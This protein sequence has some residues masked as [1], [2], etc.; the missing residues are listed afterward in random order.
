MITKTMGRFSVL[1]RMAAVLAG[2]MILT[3]GGPRA[4]ASVTYV[5]ESGDIHVYNSHL[6]FYVSTTGSNMGNLSTILLD[7]QELAGPTSNT[8]GGYFD[9]NDDSSV[10]AS[11]YLRLGHHDAANTTITP[12]KGVASTG[13]GF[14]DITIHHSSSSV[15]A[16][17]VTQH[18]VLSD[19]ENGIHM[20]TTVTNTSAVDVGVSQMRFVLVGDPLIFTNFSTEDTVS[21]PA[22]L[23]ADLTDANSV[24][25]STWDLSGYPNDPYLV[26]TGKRYFSKYDMC[27]FEQDHTVHGYW[28]AATS[29]INYGAWFAQGNKETMAG[30]PTRY[31]LMEHQGPVLLNCFFSGHFGGKAPTVTAAS[32]GTPT[33]KRTYGPFFLYFNTAASLAAARA[34][35]KTRATPTFDDAFYD[36]LGIPGYTVSAQRSTLSGQVTLSTK[37]PMTGA[38]AVLSDSG[39]DFQDAIGAG[40]HNYWAYLNADGTFQIS[41][42]TA[43]TYRLTVYKPGVFGEYDQD[44]V[45]VGAASTT[46][47]PAQVWTPP[48]HGTELWR[49]GTPDRTAAEYRHGNEYRIYWGAFDYLGEF[50]NGVIFKPGVSN[51]ATDWNYA[52][53]GAFPYGVSTAP[54]A[55]DWQIQFSLAR[56]PLAA[57]LTIALASISNAGNDGTVQVAVNGY[58]TNQRLYWSIPVASTGEGVIRSGIMGHYLYDEMAIPTSL[59]HTGANTFYLRCSSIGQ[60]VQYDA[61]RLEATLPPATVSGTALLQ[62]WTGTPQPLTFVLTPTGTTQG[63]PLTQTLTP[64]ASGAFSLPNVPA[65]TYTLGVKGAKW[66]RKDIPIDTTAGNVT[67]IALTLPTGDIN[68]DNRVSAQDYALLQAAYGSIPTSTNWNPSADLNG[69]NRVSAQDY[70]LLRGN[71]G[72]AGDL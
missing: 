56:V 55:P 39:M 44:D 23:P 25:D 17:D 65:G 46:A 10:N 31:E 58:N 35:A 68:N 42:M 59:L 60:T 15:D 16:L 4:R 49:I 36:S 26:G 72:T 51:P 43:G 63:A 50:P 67:N 29:G 3:L 20:F 38:L 41:H 47:L 1:V 34:D 61:L 21:A 57:T 22:P 52:Q 5:V 24:Q 9:W 8:V 54:H 27:G 33:W 48:A 70:A 11:G 6:S 71:Y 7:G 40:T 62:A 69:D 37:A 2:L 13:R 32:G 18:Y 45:T 66:L 12:R 14:V 30:G 53:Y 28:G 64:S 19:G